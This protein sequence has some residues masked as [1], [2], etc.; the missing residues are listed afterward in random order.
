MY[1]V[2]ESP[3]ADLHFTAHI[4]LGVKAHEGNPESAME[5]DIASTL[6]TNVWERY[7]ATPLLLDQNQVKAQ[8]H[9]VETHRHACYAPLMKE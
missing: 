4:W 6:L 5:Q 8:G 1:H 7:P 3:T 9:V 2:K